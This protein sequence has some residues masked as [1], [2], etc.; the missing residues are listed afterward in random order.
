MKA[1][2]LAVIEQSYGTEGKKLYKVVC[3]NDKEYT[4]FS[5]RVKGLKGQEIEFEEVEKEYKGALQYTMNLPK[6]GGAGGFQGK[7]GGWKPAGKSPEELE[8]GKRTMLMS[9]AKDI[10]VA[11]LNTD[12]DY[13]ISNA[14]AD[15][16]SLYNI[17]I[18]EV[19]KS[20]VPVDDT[21]KEPF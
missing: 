1:K 7:S 2:I 14:F 4:C 6:E 11:S 3:D 8:M 20:A 9:Y 13:H 21:F 17:M 15:L 19:N 16:A 18:E 12:K 10:V 5:E